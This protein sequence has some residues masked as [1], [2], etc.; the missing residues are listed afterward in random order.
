MVADRLVRSG[1]RAI[2]RNEA[3]YGPQLISAG[4]SGDAGVSAIGEAV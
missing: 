3:L 1:D 2:A 4:R